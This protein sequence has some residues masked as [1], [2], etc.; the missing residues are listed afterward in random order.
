MEIQQSEMLALAFISQNIVNSL[1]S[2]WRWKA[3]VEK[4]KDLSQ[5]KCIL[6]VY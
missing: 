2:F 3:I 1:C 6:F 4:R 5:I